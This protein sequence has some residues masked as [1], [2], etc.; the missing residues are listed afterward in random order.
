MNL[1]TDVFPA[2]ALALGEGE[3]AVMEQPARDAREPVLTGRHWGG[4]ATYGGLM[5]A[6]ALGAHACAVRGLHYDGERAVAVSFLALAF[7]QVLHVFN[8]RDRG[9]RFFKNEIVRNPWVW[10]ATALCAV[11]LAAAVYVPALS[12]VL[13]LQP[14]DGRGWL[15]VLLASGLTWVLGQAWCSLAHD[16]HAPR[17]S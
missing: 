7:A 4:I 8:V 3:G 17:R 14:P 2:L 10:G 1:V 16:F 11:L 9:S 6:C 13:H 12:H 5:T 15:V